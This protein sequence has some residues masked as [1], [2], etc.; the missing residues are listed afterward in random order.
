MFKCRKS[1]PFVRQQATADLILHI[2]VFFARGGVSAF[3]E[4]GYD[5][6][7]HLAFAVLGIIKCLP[8]AKIYLNQWKDAEIHD[9]NNLSSGMVT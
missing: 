6:L 5:M 4:F 1:V 7:G 3:N 8:V 2:L 9:I